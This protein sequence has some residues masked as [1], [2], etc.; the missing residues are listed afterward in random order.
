MHVNSRTLILV[1]GSNVAYAELSGNGDPKV[2][3]LVAMRKHLRQKGYKPLIIID[4]SLRYEI[5]D[6]QQLESLIDDQI[7]RQAPAD[8][9]ADFFILEKAQNENARVVSNDEFE[10]YQED[11]PGVKSWRLPFMI[12]NGEITLY[13]EEAE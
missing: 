8:T 1:D 11:Y 3:N 2:S 6:P 9:D 12:L 4:A 13:E 10:E 7:V 5:D